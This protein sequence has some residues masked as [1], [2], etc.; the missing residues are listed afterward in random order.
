M[1]QTPSARTALLCHSFMT[2]I[3]IDHVRNKKVSGKKMPDRKIGRIV[4]DALHK[5]WI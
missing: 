3:R 1:P 5:K 4:T 2:F